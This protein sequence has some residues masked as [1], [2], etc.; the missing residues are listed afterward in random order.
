MIPAAPYRSTP[1]FTNN[2]LPKALRRAHST[3]A[4]VW[5]LLKVLRGS[6]LYVVEETGERKIVRALG[7]VVILPQQLHSVE[8]QDDM[9]M[10]VEFYLEPPRSEQRPSDNLV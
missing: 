10:Q 8:P 5:G 4:G 6:I 1:I 7:I 3:K 9:E 2:T